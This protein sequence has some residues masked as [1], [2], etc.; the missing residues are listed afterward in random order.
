[1]ISYYHSYVLVYPRRYANKG[2]PYAF[3]M[4]SMVSQPSERRI[5]F[6][7]M[8][9]FP[10]GK[11]DTTHVTNTQSVQYLPSYDVGMGIS[12]KFYF[13]IRCLSLL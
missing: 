13:Y 3:L 7:E 6:V 11:K 2:L 8:S 4:L 5:N 9:T 1:M 10:T 12:S